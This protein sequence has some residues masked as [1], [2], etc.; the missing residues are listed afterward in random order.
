MNSFTFCDIC[1]DSKLSASQSAVSDKKLG[2]ILGIFIGIVLIIFLVMAII[3]CFI[4]R[5]HNYL[6]DIHIK[7]LTFSII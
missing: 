1:L 7:M 2:M 5:Y 4:K 6:T 3:S